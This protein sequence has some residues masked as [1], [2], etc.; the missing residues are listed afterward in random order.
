M[1][2]QRVA[3]L[4]QLLLKQK[5]DGF[6]VS[7]FYNILYLTGFKTAVPNEREA[8][9]LVTG[10]KT[11]VFVDG[12]NSEALYDHVG[13]M[14]D[15]IAVVIT[16]KD[17]LTQHLQKI[18]QKNT[19]TRIGFEAEDL[20]F[21][22]HAYLKKIIKSIR[23]IPQKNVIKKLREIK[24]ATEIEK[25]RL[26]AH[27]ADRCLEEIVKTV[28]EGQTEKEIAFKIEYWFK[29]NG[30]DMSFEPIVVVGRNAAIPHYFTKRGNAKIKKGSLIL[31]DYGVRVDDYCSDTT[32]MFGVGKVPQELQNIYNK[33]LEA[34]EKTIKKIKKGM[35]LKEIDMFC[36]KL[37]TDHRLPDFSH[38][39]GHGVGLEVHEHP[40]VSARSNDIVSSGQVFTIEPGV[41]A[42]GKYGMRIEDMI[43]ITTKGTEILTSVDKTLRVL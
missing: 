19:I 8:W 13:S 38:G 5:L 34:Q 7:N 43:L 15:I 25:I 18:M 27:V 40:V 24:G 22:E 29:K 36:R 16:S 1:Y 30:H 41:Y 26:S 9:A 6:L 35:K 10:R 37:L 20:T 3:K 4:R 23:F 21:G 11:Y 14:K 39:T 33:L 31:I 12:R 32:R 17:P 2:V 42:A 28:K